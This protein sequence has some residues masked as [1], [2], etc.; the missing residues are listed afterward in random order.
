MS[1]SPKIIEKVKEINKKDELLI[2]G[3]VRL[4]SEMSVPYE[5]VQICMAYFLFKPIWSSIYKGIKMWITE[6]GTKAIA[7]TSG[8]AVRTEF[9]I[10]RGEKVSLELVCMIMATSFNFIGVVSSIETEFNTEPQ[11]GLPEAYGVDDCLNKGYIKKGKGWTKLS[12]DK[13]QFIQ[14][15]EFKIRMVIDWTDGNQCKL[16]IFYD[17]KQLNES[18]DYTMLLPEIEDDYIWHPCFSAANGDAYCKIMSCQ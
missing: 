12:W 5:I 10:N 1:L 13:P 16:T 6:E 17:G 9:G 7:T 4:M 8:V 2:T 14:N 15:K 11:Y 18:Q 3:Y